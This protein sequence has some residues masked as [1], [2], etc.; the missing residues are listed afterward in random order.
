MEQCWT[1]PLIPSEPFDHTGLK[2]VSSR[3][4]ASADH[5]GGSKL[6]GGQGGGGGVKE[7]KQPLGQLSSDWLPSTSRR[8]PITMVSCWVS[9]SLLQLLMCVFAPLP[10]LHWVLISIFLLYLSLFR[11]LLVRGDYGAPE[12]KQ[13]KRLKGGNRLSSIPA[14]FFFFTIK[15][16]LG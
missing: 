8:S 4:S 1:R 14:T 10:L 12:L 2:G 3:T 7:K 13:S 16:N 5:H 11:L 6:A 15:T 9:G